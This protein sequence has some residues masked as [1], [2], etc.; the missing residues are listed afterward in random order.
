VEQFQSQ[1]QFTQVYEQLWQCVLQFGN[2]SAL[3]ERNRIA[4]DL[5]DSLGHALTALNIQLQAAARLWQEDPGQA[6][7]FLSEAHRLGSIAISETRQVVGTLRAE[8]AET[9]SLETLI[10]SLVK[11]FEHTTG[12]H[13]SVTISGSPT[14]PPIVVTALYRI[15]QEALNNIRK[16]A[17]ATAVHIQVCITSTNVGLLIQ[18]NGRGFKPENVNSGFGLQGMHERV[19]ALRGSIKI[20][21]EPGYG[22]KITIEI[23]LKPLSKQDKQVNQLG[24]VLVSA[25]QVEVDETVLEQTS[26]ELNVP[27]KQ[28]QDLETVL[29]ELVGPMAPELLQQAL[30]VSTPETLVQTIESRLPPSERS[31]FKNQALRF[32]QKGVAHTPVTED[33]FDPSTFTPAEVPSVL[34][35]LGEQIEYLRTQVDDQISQVDDQISQIQETALN[36][37][38]SSEHVR[39]L[40][41]LLT[42]Q[43]GPI[44]PEL[45]QR[46]ALITSSVEALIQSLEIYL[47]TAEQ[48]EFKQ[49]AALLL[50]EIASQP[51]LESNPAIKSG[52]KL[53]ETSKDDPQSID[54]DF[55]QRCKQELTQRVGPIAPI[56][57][58]KIIA[59]AQEWTRT[60]L[61]RALA[62]KIPDSQA[63]FEFEHCLLT[64]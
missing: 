17:K 29:A 30:Q 53:T 46:I 25:V 61:V 39:H 55:V 42:E 15:S 59:S 60:E 19:S 1:E 20:R 27:A 2:L 34:L 40:E 57:V 50:R 43:I 22:C 45:L 28:L 33:V 21:S 31:E 9:Q 5:H 12:V 3:Q 44:A 37:G 48:P 26:L 63:A 18:D 8:I 11:D 10:E 51:H 52:N 4:R 6:Q 41:A 49:R 47:P 24:N 36:P 56:L 16:Y 58:D 13:P 54:Q 35:A 32:L 7:Q 62:A 64:L 38:L 23:P 14:L